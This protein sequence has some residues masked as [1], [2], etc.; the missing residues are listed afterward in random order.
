MR[1]PVVSL[2]GCVLLL[3]HCGAPAPARNA[4]RDETND[5][6]VASSTEGDASF[7]DAAPEPLPPAPPLLLPAMGGVIAEPEQSLSLRD[8]FRTELAMPDDGCVRVV[9]AACGP[10]LATLGP[11]VVRSARGVLGPRGPVCERAGHT[12]LL[13]FSGLS[14]VRYQVFRTR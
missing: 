14:N 13:T 12:L 5:G 4:A 8:S 11:S 3:L 1:R 7:D 2:A 6:G 9:F 10:V